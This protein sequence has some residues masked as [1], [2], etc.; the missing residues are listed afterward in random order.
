VPYRASGLVLW[1]KADS[2]IKAIVSLWALY[3]TAWRHEALPGGCSVAQAKRG[4]SDTD[5]VAEA[6]GKHDVANVLEQGY[7]RYF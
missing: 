4:S 3:R 7:R 2:E 1:T 6:T 5:A